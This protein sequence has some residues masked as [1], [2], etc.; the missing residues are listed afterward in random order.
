METS[1]K[2]LTKD[3]AIKCVEPGFRKIVVYSTSRQSFN[4]VAS[5]YCYVEEVITKYIS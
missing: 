1:N 4:K 5:K 2:V 3:S